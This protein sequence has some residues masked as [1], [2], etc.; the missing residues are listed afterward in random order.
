MSDLQQTQH[1]LA[2]AYGTFLH[3]GWTP[4]WAGEKRLVGYSRLVW[5]KPVD[6]LIAEANDQGLQFVVSLENGAEAPAGMV[7]KQTEAFQRGLEET[8]PQVTDGKLA[9]WNAAIA[10]MQEETARVI[11]EER[12][13]QQQLEAVMPADEKGAIITYGIIGINVLVFIGMVLTGVGIFDA[14]GEGLIRWGANYAPY[15]LGG[16]YWRLLSNVFIHIGLLHLLFNMYALLQVGAYLEALLGRVRYVCAYIACG[17]CASISS[18]WWHDEPVLSAGASGAIFG[19]FGLFLALLTTDLLPKRSRGQLLKSISIFVA[20]N[21]LYGL[22]GGIDNAAHVG[23][24]LSGF[25]CGYAFL[26][27]IKGG[28][29]HALALPL[30]VLLLSVAGALAY[31]KTHPDDRLAFIRMERALTDEET[32][33]LAPY[34]QSLPDNALLQAVKGAQPNWE[35]A[36]AIVRGTTSLHLPPAEAKRRALLQQ[37]ADLRLR[38]NLLEQGQLQGDTT[39]TAALGSVNEELVKTLNALK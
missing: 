5:K 8:L 1:S 39:A 26:P 15:T 4:Q 37:Y 23:G 18:L 9:E 16:Q 14:S 27:A 31:V 7:R 36:Q 20:F 30:T 17:L 3:L 28:R 32:K 29:R 33:G 13:E 21:L 10:R 38:Q 12:E 2:L 22:K 24:L 34:K 25:V 19:M 35:R 6:T 11:A